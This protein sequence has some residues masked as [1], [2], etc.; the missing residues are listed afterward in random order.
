MEEEKKE[1]KNKE[2][3]EEGR[4]RRRLNLIAY[5]LTITPVDNWIILGH[6]ALLVIGQFSETDCMT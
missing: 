1:K 5:K 3:K 4:R 2:K 6:P